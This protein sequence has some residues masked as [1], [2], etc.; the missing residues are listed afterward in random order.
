MVR[1]KWKLK[2]VGFCLCLFLSLLSVLST[3]KVGV[4]AADERIFLPLTL[5]F[6]DEYEFK[7][8]RYN[9]T[10]VG[11]FSGITYNPL[12]DTYYIIS[13]DR[14][15]YSPA[16]FYKAKI[17]IDGEKISDVILEDVVLLKDEAGNLYP[18]NTIDAE[19]IAYTPRQTLFISSEGVVDRKIS[20]FIN[21]YDLQGNLISK[22]PIASKYIPAEKGKGIQNNLGFESLAIKA[23]SLS[24]KE[25][26]R[27]FTATEAALSQD[28]NS[29]NPQTNLN[30]RFLHYLVG[31]NPLLIGE[32]LYKIAPATST[33]LYNGICELLALPEEGHLLS[34]E[35]T[36]GLGGYGAKIFQITIANASDTTLQESL[37]NN[38]NLVPIRKKLL[39]DL[40]ELGIQLDNLEGM[41]LGPRLADGS[42]SLIVVSDNNFAPNNQQKNQFLLF[43]LSKS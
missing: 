9:D 1:G 8:N 41:T 39:L 7:D 5:E 13:D 22:L 17:R 28:L 33:T 20:P 34:L 37:N 16:R 6:L 30:A 14:S 32:H 21:E 38:D 24:P 40:G 15:Q 36:F 11:G 29:N 42:Q 18:E 19:G 25:S 35:R 31:N 2:G 26:F 27:L 3:G 10:V 43:R 12:E 23:N 4:L